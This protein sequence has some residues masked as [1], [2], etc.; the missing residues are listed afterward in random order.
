M[1]EEYDVIVLG[2][3]LKECILSGLLSVDGLKVLFFVF[4]FPSKF[5]TFLWV[6]WRDLIQV[7]ILHWSCIMLSP[8][9]KWV[10]GFCSYMSLD[11]HTSLIQFVWYY[12]ILLP[13]VLQI[14]G[15]VCHWMLHA[16]ISRPMGYFYFDLDFGV[17][18]VLLW[19][20]DARFCI[21]LGLEVAFLCTFLI[22]SMLVIYLISLMYVT[23]GSW[24]GIVFL[25]P[26]RYRNVH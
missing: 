14:I 25:V 22:S 6:C 15:I 13:L 10:I 7:W 5:H 17:V 3:G 4:C 18:L 26:F 2:T 24:L 16:V 1:D 9:V 23:V 20:L 21:E 12:L 8:Y 11:L 19:W